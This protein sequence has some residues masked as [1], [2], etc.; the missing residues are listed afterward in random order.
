MSCDYKDMPFLSCVYHASSCLIISKRACLQSKDYRLLNPVLWLSEKSY[1][2]IIRDYHMA[3]WLSPDL[4]TQHPI[5]SP[6]ALA[7]GLIM[8]EG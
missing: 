1:L 5:I 2:M 8:V 4:S 6:R 7:R 3:F